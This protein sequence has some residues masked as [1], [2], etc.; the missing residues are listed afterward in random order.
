MVDKEYGVSTLD[1]VLYT[2]RQPSNVVGE[3]CGLGVCIGS[4]Y[5]L[6]VPLG[7]SCGGVKYSLEGNGA[8]PYGLQCMV[9]LCV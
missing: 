7:F 3:H 9:G 6:G 1:T 5:D 4:V 8:L 2:F